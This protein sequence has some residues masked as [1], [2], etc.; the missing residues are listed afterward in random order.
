MKIIQL[1]HTFKSL[2]DYRN[3]TKIW[4]RMDFHWISFYDETFLDDS[5]KSLNEENPNFALILVSSS[6]RNRTQIEI[7]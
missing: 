3:L 7:V 6:T 4:K 5:S 2:P 1:Q